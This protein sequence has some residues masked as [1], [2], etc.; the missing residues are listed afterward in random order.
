M[1][2][3]PGGF[4]HHELRE[5][6][7]D[8][9]PGQ[10]VRHALVAADGRAVPDG[11]G[12]GIV[13]GSFQGVVP[14]PD[15][16]RRGGDPFRVETVE[17][18]A[19]SGF[20]GADQR[21][22]RHPDL[23]VED[24][25]L[26]VRDLRGHLDPLP[27]EPGGV[28]GDEEHRQLRL[29]GRLV[30]TG[31]GDRDHR[32]GAVDAGDVVLAPVEHPVVPVATGDGGHPVGVRAGVGLGDREGDDGVPVGQPGQ[33]GR[34]LLVRAVPLEHLDRDG[35]GHQQQQQRAACRRGL[36]GDD[37]ELGH[38]GPAAAV[39]LRHVDPDEPAVGELLPQRL[40]RLAAAAVVGVVGAAVPGG[41]LA[42]HRPQFRGLGALGEVGHGA[43]LLVRRRPGIA[44][45]RI[46]WAVRRRRMSGPHRPP[47]SMRPPPP[48]DRRN[49]RPDS[50]RLPVALPPGRGGR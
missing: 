31:P 33:P 3:Q 26:P 8:P 36:L 27:A 23:V 29:A 42:D 17:Q 45:A 30:D 43:G 1:V 13:G 11:A 49:G 37:R 39:F 6:Q 2:V 35:T 48:G 47:P 18:R 14:E 15:A 22:R 16:Q 21:R 10:R 28:G 38:A 12:A 5:V 7:R 24:G 19:G 32:G 40:L 41:D 34:A 9:R 44:R 46:R 25:E 4:R 50:S 20:R